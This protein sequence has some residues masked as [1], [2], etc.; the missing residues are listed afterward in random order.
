MSESLRDFN[1]ALAFARQESGNPSQ[2][3][4]GYCQR[5]VR[6]CYAIPSLYSSAWTQWLGADSEDKH[7]GGSPSEAPIGSALCFKGSGRYGHVD[8]AARPFLTGSDAAFS[9]DLVVY[10]EIDKVLRIAPV[11]R[12]NQ[13]YLGYL[14]AVN[15]YD[16]Q[17]KVAKPPK[18][19]Q[20]KRYKAIEKAIN[21]ME[22]A[23]AVAKRQGDK[24]DVA[25]FTAEI[26]Q[27]KKMY[28]KARRV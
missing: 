16:L 13:A 14:T 6:S 7:V 2:D 5:F 4:T 24:K 28:A 26:K 10:G 12:W 25:T 22:V 3:W 21:Q 23:L 9:N 20:N 17:L 15:G 18:P 27:L 8:L 11:T 1:E 19:K